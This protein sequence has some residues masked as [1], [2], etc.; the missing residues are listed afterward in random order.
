MA[1]AGL[2]PLAVKA[3]E[4]HYSQLSSG[5]K[6]TLSESAIQP[7]QD[8]PSLESLETRAPASLFS[9][10][11]LIKLNGGLGTGM[12]L[13]RAKTLLEVK[14]GLTFLDLIAKQI[15]HLQDTSDAG[16]PRVLLMNSFS[17]SQD[18]AKAL[19]KYPA[20]GNPGQIELLQNR[21]PKIDA[22][23]LQPAA[24]STN[25]DLEWCPPGHG[26]LYVAIA[27]SGTLD[28]LL[29]EGIR[30]A[31]ISN[32]DN[33]GATLDPRLLEYFATSG[34]PFL[35]E[36]TRRTPSDRK[37]GHLCA[38]A[39]TGAL[40]LRESA[41]CP[42]AD[43]ESFQD[44]TRHQYFNT[45]NLWLDLQAL[46][47][48]LDAN[49]GILPLPLIKNTKTLDPRDKQSTPVFQLE[50]AMG[51]AIGCFQGAGAIEV[52]RSRFAPVKTT[53]D[54]LALRSDAYTIN[55][56]YHVLLAPERQGTPPTISLS[57]HYKFVDSLE[58]LTA[59][60]I[61]SLLHCTSLTVTQPHTFPGDTTLKG[62]VIAP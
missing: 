10:T 39:S 47:D 41:Q 3:F 53:S 44:I 27:E 26:D 11:V 31:F 4:S 43:I 34:K 2:G 8:I 14:D 37:G 1:A 46:R 32:G 49:G 52:P 25:P 45:N 7:A 13:E 16:A 58:T 5:G 23:T 30:Y 35:M 40:C 55:E 6:T 57:S 60:G 50:T 21:V 12:G 22:K 18:T 33:L 28:R 62:H 9:K 24:S 56:S 38:D 59:N 15:L 19:A 17:T 20:L 61:P 36:V 54:L 29:A 51:A 48:A 42:E